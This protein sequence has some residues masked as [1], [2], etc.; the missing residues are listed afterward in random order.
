MEAQN[1]LGVHCIN[2]GNCADIFSGIN[3]MVG[4]RRRIHVDVIG[5]GRPVDARF[6]LQTRFLVD[7]RSTACG[8][9]DGQL[10]QKK[11]SL[12]R[13]VVTLP[14]H[15]RHTLAPEVRKAGLRLILIRL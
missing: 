8:C 13:S 1:H 7:I 14:K 4:W 11:S 15:C 9:A 6:T 12:A 3:G 2:T 10:V 5:F